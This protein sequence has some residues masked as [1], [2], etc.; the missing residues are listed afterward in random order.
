MSRKFSAIAAV[1]LCLLLAPRAEAGIYGD[2]LAKC[3]VRSSTADDHVTLMRW[4]F[5]A[6]AQHPALQ[7]MSTVTPQQRETSDRE[8][9]ALIQR[10]VFTD[11]RKQAVEGLKY[12]G[13]PALTTGFS[14][15]GQVATRDIFNDQHVAKGLATLGLFLDKGKVAALYKEAGVPQPQPPAPTTAH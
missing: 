6:L 14:V 7:S 3:M 11:C 12:E 10:L 8:L 1:F 13:S 5:S 2:E 15:L 9:A 4:I